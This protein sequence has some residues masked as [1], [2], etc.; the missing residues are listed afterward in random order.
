MRRILWNKRSRPVNTDARALLAAAGV[1]VGLG[2]VLGGLGGC[3]NQPVRTS[4]ADSEPVNTGLGRIGEDDGLAL[5]DPDDLVENEEGA[6]G[7]VSDQIAESARQLNVYFANI[8]ID[9]V[10]EVDP[11]SR[12]RIPLEGSETQQATQV[13]PVSNPVSNPETAQHSTTIQDPTI[14]PNVQETTAHD[15]TNAEGGVRVSLLGGSGDDPENADSDASTEPDQT[16]SQQ[17]T[18]TTQAEPDQRIDPQVRKQELARELAAILSSLASTSDDPGAAALALAGLEVL[19]P[20]ETGSLVEEGVLS[21]GELASLDAAR[22]F[23]R[24]MSSEGSL[25]S[26]GQLSAG[27]EEIQAGLHAWTGMVVTKSALCTR[28]DGFGRYETFDTYRFVAGRAQPAIVYVE[29]ERFGQREFVGPDGQ[30]RFETKLSQR[31]E[32]YH[33]ADDLNTWNR[34]AETVTDVTRN[35]LRDYYLINQITL[36][37]NLGVG[38]YHLKVVMRDLVS[39]KVAESIIPIEIVAR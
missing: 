31:L 2:M 14:E 35:H 7:S 3:E 11:A 15:A 6:F 16:E 21:D 30:P 26:P 33:V 5:P 18:Q 20:D 24:S 28:V 13:D 32:L 38:R 36:P 22:A 34:A 1:C 9:G 25:A 37:A 39:E 27:L 10:D 19:L 29:L 12:K 4:A 23:L 8:E 17:P